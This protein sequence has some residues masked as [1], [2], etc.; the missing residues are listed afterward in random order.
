M[1]ASR[2]HARCDLRVRP[3]FTVIEL[4]ITMAI[5]GFVVGAITVGLYQINTL[6]RYQRDSL[7]ANQTLESVATIMNRDIVGASQGSVYYGVLSLSVPTYAVSQT[8]PPVA[9]SISYYLAGSN[10]VRTASGGGASPLTI[11]R[12]VSSIAYGPI[13]PMTFA[14]TTTLNVTVTSQ[15]HN[16]TRIATLSF[17]RR[18]TP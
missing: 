10:L 14:I 15:V 9:Q 17:R 6:T 3:G 4:L 11:A 1:R 8:S 12:N 5:S 18:L 7:T 2:H 16:Q 13:D